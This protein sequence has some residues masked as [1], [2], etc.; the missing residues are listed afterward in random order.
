M[1]MTTGQIAERVLDR[2]RVEVPLGAKIVRS[3]AFGALRYVLLIPIPFVM[4]PFILRKIGV[5][6]YGTWSVFLAINAMTSLADLG[7]VGTISKFVAEYYAHRDFDGL[8]R[9]LSSAVGLFVFLALAVALVVAGGTGLLTATL[10]R[11]TYVS[12]QELTFLL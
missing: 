1:P 11:G 10:F 9:L 2:T 7:L 8:S 4:T 3:V 12:H 5:A 6:G